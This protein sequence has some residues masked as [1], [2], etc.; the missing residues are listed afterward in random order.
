MKREQLIKKAEKFAE[1]VNKQL[2]GII[3]LEL[4]DLYEGGIFVARE[5]GKAGAKKRY[6]L[7]DYRGN[8][9]IRGFETVRRDWCE[10]SK[11]I[12]R[13]V[14]KIILHD[15]NPNKALQ[16][17][18]DTVKKIKE[19]KVAIDDLT[20][21]EQITRPLSA[22]EAIGPHVRAAQKAKAKG[23]PVG[24][25]TVIGFVITKGS[26]KISDRAEPV[27]D[28]KQNQYDPEYYIG[29]QVLPASM[30]VLK[31]LGY[32]EQEVLSGKTQKKLGAWFKK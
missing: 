9:E 10:L 7:V 25:G 23:R 30:R 21:F 29:H 13:E 20:I 14:L 5:K 4:R 19:G 16:L 8:L 1:E 24:E 11:R 31:A 17:V 3:E 22:Y 6:A 15:K 2:P 27:E 18:R 26:G 12:Q 28:V 32:T